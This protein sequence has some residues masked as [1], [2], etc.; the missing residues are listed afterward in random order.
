M[1]NHEKVHRL[2]KFYQ[3][4]WLNLYIGRNTKLT[5]KVKNNFE[6]DNFKFMN[7]AV[8]EKKYLKC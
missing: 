1:K 6:K 2:N 5:I 4:V 7:N 8:L 3:N